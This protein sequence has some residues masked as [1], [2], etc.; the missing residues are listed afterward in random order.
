M[1]TVYKI[2]STSSVVLATTSAQLHDW[3]YVGFFLGG[4]I[5]FAIWEL[6]A[7]VERTRDEEKEE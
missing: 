6:T 4:G 1:R 7:V 3:N 5:I 2:I